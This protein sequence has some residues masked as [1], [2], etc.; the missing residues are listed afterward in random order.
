MIED[1]VVNFEELISLND[2]DSGVSDAT[3]DE[4]DSLWQKNKWTNNAPLII[5]RLKSLSF[6]KRI[7][8]EVMDRFLPSLK[9]KLYKKNDILFTEDKVS[10]IINGRFIVRKH[11]HSALNYD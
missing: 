2:P 5:N 7:P 11:E 4:I 6:F 3:R 1:Y 8:V 9:V 10:I